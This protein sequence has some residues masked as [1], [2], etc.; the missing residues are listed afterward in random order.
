MFHAGWS[1]KKT[2]LPRHI[3]NNKGALR[4]LI[5]TGWK[6]RVPNKCSRLRPTLPGLDNFVV[7]L[8]EAVL[9]CAGAARTV[10]L[11]HDQVL[12]PQA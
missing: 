2:A 10:Q 12:K 8:G 1:V 3:G 4:A 5:G 11:I 9:A 7:D 6:C